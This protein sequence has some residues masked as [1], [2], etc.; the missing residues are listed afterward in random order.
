MLCPVQV[1]L[2]SD[3]EAALFACRGGVVCMPRWRCLRAT[4]S[5]FPSNW[6]IGCC[7]GGL[8][9][10]WKMTVTFFSAFTSRCQSFSQLPA[11]SSA[12]WLQV[13]LVF[14]QARG[15]SMVYIRKSRGPNTEPWGTPAG[16]G[17]QDD[18][19][20]KTFTR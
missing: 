5:T 14:V 8:L 10:W 7:A 20:S 16:M 15:R 11:V 13:V 1:V 12:N 2:E 4:V 18:V 9:S 3:A 17:S 6:I 19:V